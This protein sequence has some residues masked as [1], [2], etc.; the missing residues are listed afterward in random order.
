MWLV[1][2]HMYF[3]TYNRNKSIG[4]KH[5]LKKQTMFVNQVINKLAR[6]VFI[7][8]GRFQK[9]QVFKPYLIPLGNISLRYEK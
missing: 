2:L 3:V 1:F 8:S 4:S 9:I 5:F 7:Y 6:I